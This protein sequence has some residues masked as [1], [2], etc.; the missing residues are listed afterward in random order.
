MFIDAVQLR[1]QIVQLQQRQRKLERDLKHEKKRN[2]A[3]QENNSDLKEQVTLLNAFREE[4]E[5][6]DGSDSHSEQ[7]DEDM[8]TFN[9]DVSTVNDIKEEG[10]FK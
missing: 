4:Q 7:E 3:L 8:E 10:T 2:K 5:K 6:V 1:K 9:A